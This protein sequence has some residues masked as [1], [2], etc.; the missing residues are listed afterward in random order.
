MESK[1]HTVLHSIR[2]VSTA[3]QRSKYICC[4]FSLV[5]KCRAQFFVVLFNYLFVDVTEAS[6]EADDRCNLFEARSWG[7]PV[8]ALVSTS[9]LC[10]V[11]SISSIDRLRPT[12]MV[13]LE[14]LLLLFRIR[15]VFICL[16]GDGDEFFLLRVCFRLLQ[17]EWVVVLLFVVVVDEEEERLMDADEG[18]RLTF[19]ILSGS[20]SFWPSSSLS[21]SPDS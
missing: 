9:E 3:L 2:F 5:S 17:V 4:V 6:V 8:A 11:E 16:R 18:T 21:S 14:L 13:L 19:G 15:L 1:N 10:F 7:L 12:M 20:I